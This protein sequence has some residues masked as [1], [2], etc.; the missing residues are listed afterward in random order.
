MAPKRRRRKL[1]LVAQGMEVP[2]S[3]TVVASGPI[4]GRLKIRGQCSD[5]GERVSTVQK[6]SR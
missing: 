5:E 6:D 3:S 1:D 4:G 2:K